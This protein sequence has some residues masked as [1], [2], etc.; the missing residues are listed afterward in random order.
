MPRKTTIMCAG[1]LMTVTAHSVVASSVTIY[2]GV[3]ECDAL[4]LTVS[5]RNLYPTP[6]D[7]ESS[8]YLLFTIIPTSSSCLTDRSAVYY[9]GDWHRFDRSGVLYIVL[10]EGVGE[11]EFVLLYE[12]PG[13]DG[14]DRNQ[15]PVTLRTDHGDLMPSPFGTTTIAVQEAQ[16]SDLST[17][18]ID[19]L[20]GGYLSTLE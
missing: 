15:V 9:D 19:E 16:S 3:Y 8:H 18:A 13:V 2:E 17:R 10:D 5:N 4:S 14:G 7:G 1:I 11:F 20:V 6:G 12:I